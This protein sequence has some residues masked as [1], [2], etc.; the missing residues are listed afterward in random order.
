V[1]LATVLLQAADSDQPLPR[2]VLPAQPNPTDPFLYHD[3]KN[4]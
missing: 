2:N 3:P 4:D 1:I